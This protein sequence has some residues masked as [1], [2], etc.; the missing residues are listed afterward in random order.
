MAQH[1]R[2][3]STFLATMP[4]LALIVTATL[5]GA[6]SAAADEKTKTAQ[7]AL[8][9]LGYDPGVIDGAWGASSRKA[10]NEFQKALGFKTTKGLNAGLRD[11]LNLAAAG[12]EKTEAPRGD[13][14]GKT[15][16]G[17]D[18]WRVY[19]N[20]N[21]EKKLK[22]RDG[23]TLIKKWRKKTDGTFCEYTF[24]VKKNLCGTE[25]GKGTVTLKSGVN[26]TM[27]KASGKKMFTFEMVDGNQL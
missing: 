8:A 22:T 3:T 23:K 16:I 11:A 7:E 4:A 26:W 21:G 25:I 18:G 17:T 2:L 1:R 12:A 5:G 24:S 10:L 6:H 13:K 20:P 27:F 15:L 19:Y 14:I 9:K